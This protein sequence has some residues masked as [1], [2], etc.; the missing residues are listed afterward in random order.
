MT[1]SALPNINQS[2]GDQ[3][4]VLSSRHAHMSCIHICR[5]LKTQLAQWYRVT[6]A[7]ITG[8]GK[9]GETRKI[10]EYPQN[11]QQI[12]ATSGNHV[13]RSI[14][15]RLFTKAAS[16]RAEIV[17]SRG[18]ETVWGS[19]KNQCFQPV[20]ATEE[21]W[22][23]GEGGADVCNTSPLGHAFY[24][25][26]CEAGESHWRISTSLPAPDLSPWGWRHIV[27]AQKQSIWTRWGGNPACDQGMK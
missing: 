8:R 18:T 22:G 11:V 15:V 19:R 3:L 12:S 25:V 10:S 17:A 1:G 21:D 7:Q 2:T 26:R 20:E 23:A 13:I 14:Y 6:A 16:S 9:S 27:P 5:Q 24:T 4:T